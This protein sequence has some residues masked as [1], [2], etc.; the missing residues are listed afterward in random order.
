MVPPRG[1]IRSEK[2]AISLTS[3]PDA[4]DR[5]P[6]VLA[7]SVVATTIAKDLVLYSLFTKHVIF[8]GTAAQLRALQAKLKVF[9]PMLKKQF[10]FPREGAFAGE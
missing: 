5:D 8:V 2:F 7:V 6:L 3:R 10:Y 9:E 4:P 1:E